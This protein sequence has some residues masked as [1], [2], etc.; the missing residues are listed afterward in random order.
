MES[1]KTDRQKQSET[2]HPR[3]QSYK[4]SVGEIHTAMNEANQQP[5]SV[6]IKLYDNCLRFRQFR[7]EFVLRRASGPYDTEP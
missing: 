4:D 6:G 2:E 1:F 5:N 3:M 7:R